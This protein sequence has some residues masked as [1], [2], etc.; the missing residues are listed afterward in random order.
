MIFRRWIP[1]VFFCVMGVFIS[2][3]DLRAEQ[4]ASQGRVE[5]SSSADVV[6]AV[7]EWAPMVGENIEGFGIHSKRVIAVFEAMGYR[8][9]LEFLPWQRAYEL[10]RRGDYVATFSWL[11][12]ADRLEL[13]YLP[14]YP[15]ARAH[16]TVFYKKSRFPNGLDLSSLEDIAT[17]G[18]HPVGVASYWYEKAYEQLGIS[19]DIV[20]NPESAWRFLD[21][22]RADVFMEEEQVGRKDMAA[23]LGPAAQEVYAVSDPVKTDD[24]FILFS[25]AHPDGRRLAEAFDA[26]MLSEEGRALCRQ[27]DVCL[28]G[29]Q[30]SMND[31]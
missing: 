4:G 29:A 3:N 15:I 22:D 16:Q 26:Y 10:T 11:P 25:R 20:T 13:F 8:P 21:A 23:Y 18:L 9:Q 7:G 17:F 30:P 19:A 2:I 5:K 27:W 14:R 6:F 31:Q 28:K 24:M 12:S 1:L